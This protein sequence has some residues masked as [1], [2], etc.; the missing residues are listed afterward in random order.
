[1]CAGIPVLFPLRSYLNC[2][3]RRRTSAY[4][5]QSEGADG[6]SGQISGR[7]SNKL[8]SSKSKTKTETE[9]ALETFVSA[10]FRSEEAPSVSSG[11]ERELVTVMGK[12]TK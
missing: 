7:P 1:V 11:D 12:D 5:R 8:S 3:G 10:E 4:Y 2:G 6:E 9:L